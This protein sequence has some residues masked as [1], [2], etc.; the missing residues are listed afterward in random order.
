M[1]G[2]SQAAPHVTGAW[3]A[4]KSL[5]PAA[6]VEDVLAVLQGTGN[7]VSDTRANTVAGF[8]GTGIQIPRIQ[9]DLAMERFD[10]H[11]GSIATGDFN[12]DGRQDIA[13]GSPNQTVNNKADAGEVSILYG[14]SKGAVPFFNRHINQNSKD[15][16]GKK[17]EGGAE[18]GDR[19]GHSLATGDFNNDGCGDLAVGVPYESIGTIKAGLVQVF[20]GKPWGF[21][22]NMDQHWHQNITNVPGGIENGDKFGWSL[23][24]GDFNNDGLDDLAIGM[25]TESIG[26]VPASGAVTIIYGHGAGLDAYD[27]QMW[28]QDNVFLSVEAGDLFGYAITT[29]YFNNDQY[30]DLA[31]GAPRET[32]T[33]ID[34]SGADAGAVTVLYGSANGVNT[35][36]QDYFHQG[37][38]NNATLE[39]GD[40]FGFSLASGNFNND[41][42]SDLV[43]GAPF[44]DL[45]YT[46]STVENAGIVHVFR[47]SSGGITLTGNTIWSQNT[48]SIKGASEAGDY[49]G[50]SVA[51]GDFDNDGFDDLAVG[52]PFED[53]EYTTST[54]ENAGAVNVIRGSTTGLTAQGNQLWYQSV[55][56]IMGSSEDF[57]RF[58]E[59]VAAGDVNPPLSKTTSQLE[60]LAVRVSGEDMATSE[61]GAVQI[62]YG[63]SGIGLSKWD[64]F[65]KLE[66]F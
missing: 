53:L 3:A 57:D 34:D 59:A 63:K 56:N 51:S 54:V 43:I 38:L 4:L 13:M 18:A 40:G 42:F 29:G 20:Y 10:P 15:K 21:D 12:C 31:I 45:E 11:R 36:G 62:F 16:F 26:T 33:T 17:A 60:D 58:G 6:R 28:H 37:K 46:N 5:N 47:G 35:N 25:P 14:S 44:E 7:L 48:A 39:A 9:L 8:A 50:Y 30:S 23:A 49:F 2:T 32:S 24:T 61:S 1:T 19:F 55:S 52:V 64:K 22:M 66:D 65:I 27:S 41:K